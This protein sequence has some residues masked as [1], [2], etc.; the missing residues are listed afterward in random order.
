VIPAAFDYHRASS[1]DEAVSLLTQY[2]DDARLLA[3]GHSLLPLMRLRLA[4]PGVLVDIGRVDGLDDIAVTD[5]ELRIGALARHHDV[6]TSEAVHDA[7]PLVAAVTGQIGDPQVRHRGTVGGSIAH[8]DPASDLPAALLALQATL[9]ARGPNGERT[10][11]VDDF[12]TSLW[13]TALAH[14]EVLTEIRVPAANGRGWS[15]QKFNRRAQDWAVVAVA[16][17][18]ADGS[19]VPAGVG[20]VN[21]GATP[22]RANAVEE[23][24]AAGAAPDEA[25][26]QAD[27]GTEP[28]DDLNA[29]P[30]YRRHLARVLTRRALDAASA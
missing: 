8:G 28:P 15:F 16:A 13:E 23:A 6:A 27:A 19:G 20:L 14:D 22:L 2:G 12:F 29:S 26:D 5:G 4:V 21:M 1:V 11:P 3:G 17:V 30:E 10:I 9:V 25:A 18:L 24:L 7:A